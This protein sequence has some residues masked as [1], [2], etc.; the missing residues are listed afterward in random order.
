MSTL[1]S[2]SCPHV[3]DRVLQEANILNIERLVKK[4]LKKKLK[5]ISAT[6]AA[7]EYCTISA[8]TWWTTLDYILGKWTTSLLTQLLLHYQ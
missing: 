5:S 7:T 4:S 6:D 8:I 3:Q 2:A 1:E